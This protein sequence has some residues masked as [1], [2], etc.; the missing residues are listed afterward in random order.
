M[1]D[2]LTSELPWYIARIRRGVDPDAQEL[3]RFVARIER[4][5]GCWLWTGALNSWGY[6][7]FYIRGRH[8][9]APRYSYNLFTGPIPS[10]A[11]IDHVCRNPACVN[12][13]HLEAVSVSEN[14][15]RGEWGRRT[16]CPHGHAYDEA[17][18]Y[19]DPAGHRHCRACKRERRGTPRPKR[20]HC[21]NGHEFTPENTWRDKHGW[22]HC[23]TCR[24]AS[25]RSLRARRRMR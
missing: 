22:R 5:D 10:G 23:R 6:G 1:R 8:E 17:N 20:T 18:T 14:A 12:P 21:V 7:H 15:R 13:A 24:A 19:V 11:V 9:R 4:S 3:I 25:L 2:M 16:R